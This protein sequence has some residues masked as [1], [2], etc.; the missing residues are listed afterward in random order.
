MKKKIILVALGVEFVLAFFTSL[1]NRSVGTG[2]KVI[3]LALGVVCFVAG[4]AR[5]R[6]NE[7]YAVQ[8]KTPEDIVRET[9]EQRLKEAEATGNERQAKYYRG[10]LDEG[11]QRVSKDY[12][13]HEAMIANMKVD[14]TVSDA[15]FEKECEAHMLR[16]F[17]F[18]NMFDEYNDEPLQTNVF[19]TYALFLEKRGRYV[20]AASVCAKALRWG[21]PNDKT[22]GGMAGRLVRMVKKSGGETTPEIEDALQKY[23]N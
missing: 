21:F 14:K 8:T 3:M 17:G 22:Q 12:W 13:H 20:E 4:L 11:Y 19:K 2:A 9:S 18:K 10:Q 16:A 6:T 7:Y 23:C 15:E 1:S 5:K